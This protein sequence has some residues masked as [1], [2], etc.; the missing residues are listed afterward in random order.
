MSHYQ[1][2]SYFAIKQTNKRWLSL[3]RFV[4]GKYLG[5]PIFMTS[6]LKNLL[7]TVHRAYVFIQILS[8]KKNP[9]LT[10]GRH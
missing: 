3:N 1:V 10:S 2:S 7:N 4:R 8:P 5:F 9:S 6:S